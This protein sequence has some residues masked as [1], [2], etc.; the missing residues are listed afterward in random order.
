MNQSIQSL[1]ANHSAKTNKKYLDLYTARQMIE[2][3]YDWSKIIKT[4]PYVCVAL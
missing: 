2:S 4:I 1:C 3:Q